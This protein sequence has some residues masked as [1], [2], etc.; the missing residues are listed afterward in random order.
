MTVETLMSRKPF[1]EKLYAAQDLAEVKALFESEGVEM[2]ENDLM[3][4]LMPQGDTLT[5][6]E[7]EEVAG[8]GSIMNWLRSRLGGGKGAF[9]GG[10]SMGG[11]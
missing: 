7:L 1:L 2:T 6:D 8:G 11:R 3:K 9:G 10:G 4:M 5:E